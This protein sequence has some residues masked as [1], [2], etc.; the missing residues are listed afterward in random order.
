MK[1]QFTSFFSS[2]LFLCPKSNITFRKSISSTETKHNFCLMQSSIRTRLTT[3]DILFQFPHV[4]TLDYTTYCQ[5]TA[6]SL[7]SSQFI[8]PI[9]NFTSGVDFT[10]SRSITP[11]KIWDECVQLH[12]LTDYLHP[13]AEK[14]PLQ[15]GSKVCS[16]LQPGGN[17]NIE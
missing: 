15:T 1:E 13:M 3:L 6:P 2:L 11:P 7:T 16:Q 10:L 5:K 14:Y 17:L 4:C 12:C 8:R 9:L